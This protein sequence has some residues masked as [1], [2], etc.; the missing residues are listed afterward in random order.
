ML[1]C[2]DPADVAGKDPLAVL[3]ASTNAAKRF[4]ESA[5]PAKNTVLVVNGAGLIAAD[6]NGM[7]LW[8]D[9]PDIGLHDFTRFKMGPDGTARAERD[10]I[11]NRGASDS[12]V[13]LGI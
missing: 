4:A 5:D 10:V 1:A 2:E 6:S 11:P 12:F 9:E 13:I 7:H 3:T 8:S